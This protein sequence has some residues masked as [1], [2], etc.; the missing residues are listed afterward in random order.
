ME[1]ERNGPKRKGE[2][3]AAPNPL[4]P[5]G[6]QGVIGSGREAAA[7]GVNGGGRQKPAEKERAPRSKTPKQLARARL[8]EALRVGAA[9]ATAAA[10]G[11]EE[12][13]GAGVSSG[14][15]YPGHASAPAHARPLPR[16][17][18]P[19]VFGQEHAAEALAV[20]S[21][22]RSFGAPLQLHPFTLED[23]CTALER[24]QAPNEAAQISPL[25]AELHLRLLRVVLR[26]ASK[27]QA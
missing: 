26:D 21:F 16:G 9:K 23:L 14:V 1:P 25:L 11:A 5:L 12:G 13:E 17:V 15:H 6:V 19:L 4:Q 20:W 24:D 22:A 18:V 2:A 27:P 7:G 10:A 3:G 8:D